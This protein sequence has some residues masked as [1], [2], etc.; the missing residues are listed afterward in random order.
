MKETRKISAAEIIWLVCFLALSF[1][2]PTLFGK[3]VGLILC[4]ALAALYLR[5][6][7]RRK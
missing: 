4:A 6:K 5:G 1:Y 2:P 3:A 7:Q